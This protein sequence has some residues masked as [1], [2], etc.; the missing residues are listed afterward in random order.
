MDLRTRRLSKR[1]SSPRQLVARFSP[2][3]ALMTF[4]NAASLPA[5]YRVTINM[6][7]D[8]LDKSQPMAELEPFYTA[9]AMQLGDPE[10]EKQWMLNHAKDF[11]E[12]FLTMVQQ[13]YPCEPVE[14]LIQY[15][16]WYDR[17]KARLS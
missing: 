11:Y 7:A 12:A 17:E 6:W 2:Y 3:S 5:L 15:I 1:S 10:G 9:I 14:A 16:F 13:P 8:D 4:A